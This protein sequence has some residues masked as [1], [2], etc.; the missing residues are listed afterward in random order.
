MKLLQ[1]RG[2]L[3]HHTLQSDLSLLPLSSPYPLM[4]HT[5]VVY[6]SIWVRPSHM[7]L[8]YHSHLLPSSPTQHS[9]LTSHSP[10]HI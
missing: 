2:M 4:A 9:A 3:R 5:A 1:C 6:V 7:P 8:Y 10:L